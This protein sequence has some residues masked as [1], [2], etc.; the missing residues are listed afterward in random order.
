[1]QFVEA[2]PANE[3]LVNEWGG[4][5]IPRSLWEF[6]IRGSAAVR[7]NLFRE[8]YTFLSQTYL[9]SVLSGGLSKGV[10][11]RNLLGVNPLGLHW[12]VIHAKTLTHLGNEFYDVLQRAK[13]PL[14]ARRQFLEHIFNTVE[15]SDPYLMHD[16]VLPHLQASDYQK[17]A[18]HLKQDAK[19]L[20]KRQSELA[21]YFELSDHGLASLD[22]QIRRLH[23]D[24]PV[25]SKAYGQARLKQSIEAFNNWQPPNAFMNFIKSKLGLQPSTPKTWSP[26]LQKVDAAALNLGLTERLNLGALKQISRQQLLR[27]VHTFMTQYVDRALSQCQP[28]GVISDKVTLTPAL[29]E[30]IT[31]ALFGTPSDRALLARRWHVKNLMPRFT[32]GLIPYALRSRPLMT[33]LPFMLALVAGGMVGFI[34]NAITRKLNGGSN[35]SP[36]EHF[37]VERAQQKSS[38]A[39]TSKKRLNLPAKNNVS[40]QN[41]VPVPA[42]NAFAPSVASPALPAPAIFPAA[43]S[44]PAYP[45]VRSSVSPELAMLPAYQPAL[46]P[47]AT[48]FT[49]NAITPFSA[50]TPV[51]LMPSPTVPFYAASFSKPVVLS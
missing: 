15:P 51:G 26:W 30:K 50:S 18:E 25:D 19:A 47:P 34:N 2:N 35:A 17:A 12:G 5:T 16:G 40:P 24:V 32:D 36:L 33:W 46:L 21:K 38:S 37:R 14:A 31:N 7:E 28:D 9:T 13:T 10:Y 45:S 39:T 8:Q 27:D 1:M 22:A 48:A 42:V 4:F 49:S 23:P 11:N 3:L 29:R 41:T 43:V 6:A 44:M 20:R